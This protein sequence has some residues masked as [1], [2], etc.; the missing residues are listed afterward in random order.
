VASS[1][2]PKRITLAYKLGKNGAE[3]DKSK[4]GGQTF[5]PK[6]LKSAALGKALDEIVKKLFP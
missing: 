5:D 3:L 1:W 4:E 2:Y 6:H